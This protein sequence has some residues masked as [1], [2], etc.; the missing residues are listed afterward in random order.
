[1][2]AVVLYH[3]GCPDGFGAAYAV[4]R[5][6][7]DGAT[8][9]PVSYGQPPPPVPDGADVYILD[10]S[11]PARV[12]L[13][14]WARAKSLTVLDH[15]KTAAAD[16]AGL[17]GS[18]PNLAVRF[19]L[20][21]SG[22]VL[23]WEHFHPG[24][25]VPALIDYICDRDL[26]L[27]LLPDS[28]EFSA[29]LS[30]EPRDFAA[31]DRLACLKPMTPPWHRFV[32]RGSVVLEHTRKLVDALCRHAALTAVGDHRVPAVNTP[33]FISEVGERLCELHPDAPFGATWFVNEDGDE[34]WSL[35]SRNG[36][37]GFDVS[38]V[39]RALGGGGHAA[40]AGFVRHKQ[41]V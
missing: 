38:E 7:G 16:L 15:H 35:R 4:W 31:W 18:K 41:G 8:Y 19:D 26:W 40:A 6:L 5:A 30:L 17:D 1:V 32:A 11:Y 29:A 36:F 33:L 27:W 23:A 20:T 21:K 34:V 24:E 12:L 37:D 25:P 39:A 10:F 13:A 14:L 2:N 3:G 22:A 28:R 9:A